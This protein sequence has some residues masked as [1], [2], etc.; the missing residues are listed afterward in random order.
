MT[1]V[2]SIGTRVHHLRASP[3][4]PTWSDLCRSPW[5]IVCAQAIAACSTTRRNS[6]ERSE[7]MQL[8]G[9]DCP[10]LGVRTCVTS[11]VRRQLAARR[12]IDAVA[13]QVVGLHDLVNL[14]RAFVDHRALAVAVEAADRILVGIAVGAVNLHGVAGRALGRDGREP[15]REPGLARVAAARVLQ[16]ARRAATA[17]APPGSRTP[18]ARSFPSR[19]G[20]A[21]I[22]TPNVLRSFA[23]LT[24]ASRQARIR[25][26]APAATV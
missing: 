21:P 24:L 18:S 8:E 17:A 5:P 4:R 15:L 19:A 1:I 23:Y 7:S 22:S 14:A 26:V 9:C 2:P 6:S 16:P 13:E 20:A 3:R 12:P 25:P 10:R 11:L